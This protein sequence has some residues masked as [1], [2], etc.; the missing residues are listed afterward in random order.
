MEYEFIKLSSLTKENI[1]NKIKI[2]IPIPK[3]NS[4]KINSTTSYWKSGTGYGTSNDMINGWDITK[5]IK[6]QEYE[7]QKITE[8]LNNINKLISSS[9]ISMIDGSVLE[10]YLINHTREFTI[11]E[12]EKNKQL[13]R[14][15]FEVLY[16]LINHNISQLLINTIYD[17]IKNI[18]EDIDDLV[19]N[20]NELHS[21]QLFLLIMHT[22]R[23]FSSKYQKIII[24]IN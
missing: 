8:S 13:Y 9:T 12:L 1:D 5:Y 10:S 11:L 6:E 17:N 19:R 24:V 18:S 20:N 3:Q 22:F 14:A 23:L 2:N 16:S 21:H 4:T 7:I 15:I